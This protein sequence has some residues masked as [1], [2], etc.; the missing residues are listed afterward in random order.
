MESTSLQYEPMPEPASL[1]KTSVTALLEALQLLREVN[2]NTCSR[3][4]WQACCRA[5]IR[6]LWAVMH[7][8]IPERDLMRLQVEMAVLKKYLSL[9]DLRSL[10]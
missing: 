8:S 6:I 4:V 9:P 1:E 10:S 3:Q 5:R 2:S 7:S